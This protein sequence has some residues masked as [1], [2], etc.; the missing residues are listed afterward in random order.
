MLYFPT[1]DVLLARTLEDIVGRGVGSRGLW[2]IHW[3]INHAYLKGFR[4]FHVASLDAGTVVPGLETVGGR[5][6]FRFDDVSEQFQRELGQL[7]GVDISPEVT[8]KR[9]ESLDGFRGAAAARL[10]IDHLLSP[11]HIDSIKLSLLSH[12]LTYGTVGLAVILPDG[13]RQRQ[14]FLEVIPPWQLFPIPANVGSPDDVRGVVRFRW[15][16]YRPF[17]RMYEN[18][19]EFPRGKDEASLQLM[20]MPHGSTPPK[21]GDAPDG[22]LGMGGGA[23]VRLR[24]SL[25]PSRLKPNADNTLDEPF[26]A[27][28]EVWAYDRN[29][30]LTNKYT[31]LGTAIVDKTVWENGDGPICP[32]AVLRTPPVEGFYGWPWISSLIPLAL[33]T[34]KMLGALFR[35]VQELD[36][37]G[38][39]V[40]PANS[41]IKLSDLTGNNRPKIAFAQP[42][43]TGNPFRIEHVQ[44]FNTGEAPGRIASTAIQLLDRLGRNS[45]LYR[46][47]MPGRAESGVTLGL[48]YETSNIARKATL[49]SLDEAMSLMYA[50]VVDHGHRTGFTG[51]I[52]M[53]IVDDALAGLVVDPDSKLVSLAM[54][55]LPRVEDLIIHI[56][57]RTP[58]LQ[59]QQR[60][61]PVSYTHLT[62]PTIYS[63]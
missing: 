48:L 29:H 27:V 25:V 6:K 8:P 16:P 9:V 13:V 11:Q 7:V 62:L 51:D 23:S 49:T 22:T 57:E 56:R 55:P 5:M 33:E 36:T 15:V 18:V 60:Q 63:V 61:E 50:A 53:S 32:I 37:Y 19:L 2:K 20:F 46:G 38:I 43:F 47:E 26:V 14:A 45:P 12:L 10:F 59:T 1:D 28:T 4:R 52:S 3:H 35:N 24:D 30:R 21:S 17:K 40:L 34:E 41:G 44:P 58:K 42:D 31:M 39:I 54:N